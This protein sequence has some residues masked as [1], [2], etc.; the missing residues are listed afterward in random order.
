[1]L[2]VMV[3]GICADFGAVVVTE[4][5]VEHRRVGIGQFQADAVP[6]LE[7]PRGRPDFD[8]EVVDAAWF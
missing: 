2:S 7:D 4:R 5:G 6:F 8:L 3:D 1:M